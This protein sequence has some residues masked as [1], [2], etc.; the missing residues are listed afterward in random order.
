MEDRFRRIHAILI[1]SCGFL[2]LIMLQVL[3]VQGGGSSLI[4]V[5]TVPFFIMMSV[6]LASIYFYSIQPKTRKV[7]SISL[8]IFFYSFLLISTFWMFP[9]K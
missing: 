6:I 1:I 3:P 7:K 5:V 8:L 4:F 2:T 9:F